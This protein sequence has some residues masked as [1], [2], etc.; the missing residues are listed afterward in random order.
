MNHLCRKIGGKINKENLLADDGVKRVVTP[1]TGGKLT[2]LLKKT[3]LKR[4][5]G[6]LDFRGHEADVHLKNEGNSGR[7]SNN[8]FARFVKNSG[9]FILQ[10]EYLVLVD[11][12]VLS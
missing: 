2:N 4:W 5:V 1:E 10:N 8:D 3:N 12:N 7:K 11:A 9:Y 6:T